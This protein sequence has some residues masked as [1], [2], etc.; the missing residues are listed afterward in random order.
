MESTNNQ[1]F[2]I[3]KSFGDGDSYLQFELLEICYTLETA[4]EIIATYFDDKV[5]KK[6][7]EYAS[8]RRKWIDSP[9]HDSIN[10]SNN[11]TFVG[12]RSECTNVFASDSIAGYVIEVIEVR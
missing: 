4:Q 10:A 8:E 9:C 1:V 5:L 3:F 7:K 6:I 11:Y 12:K 2:A